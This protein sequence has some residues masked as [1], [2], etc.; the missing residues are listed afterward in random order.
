M[1]YV[2]FLLASIIIILL[3]IYLVPL[4]F[5]VLRFLIGLAIIAVFGAGV[6]VGTKFNKK[7]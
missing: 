5:A 1:K 2:Y 6:W 7:E 4:A 3:A